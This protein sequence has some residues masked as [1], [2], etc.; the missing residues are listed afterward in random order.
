MALESACS[1]G[2]NVPILGWGTWLG[3]R[4]YNS[5]NVKAAPCFGAFI[6]PMRPC[7]VPWLYFLQ[8]FWPP[9]LLHTWI[10]HLASR[11]HWTLASP[12]YWSTSQPLSLGWGT[13]LIWKGEL[14]GLRATKVPQPNNL[15]SW[16]L[17]P[18]TLV[19][20]QC[21]LISALSCLLWSIRQLCIPDPGSG[22]L[23]GYKR[24]THTPENWF[25]PLGATDVEVFQGNPKWWTSLILM[26]TVVHKVSWL[27]RNETTVL[28]IWI[29]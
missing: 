7:H 8:G 20:F 13:W 14:G 22:P 29:L 23:S 1:N 21:H 2:T 15:T 5:G 6:S 4:R 16:E 3:W 12:W 25:L 24:E 9:Y 17:A 28:H 18:S 27:S 10:G 26:F 11:W 19:S